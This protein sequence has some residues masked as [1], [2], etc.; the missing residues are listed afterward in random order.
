MTAEDW[1]TTTLSSKVEEDQIRLDEVQT[2]PITVF[3]NFFRVAIEDDL[4]TDK[5]LALS[6]SHTFNWGDPPME[7]TETAEELGY[8]HFFDKWHD[9]GII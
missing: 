8:Q 4:Q 9:E 1:V 2:V 5:Y 7:Y 3:C 6:G